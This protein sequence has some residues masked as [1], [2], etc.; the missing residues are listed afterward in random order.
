V[1]GGPA[2]DANLKGGDIITKADGGDVKE[3]LDIERALGKLKPRDSI[4]LTL[5]RGG[6]TLNLS[7]RLEELPRQIDELPQG[8]L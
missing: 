2:F 3:P 6:R 8:V 1:R 4:K 7:V 5:Q